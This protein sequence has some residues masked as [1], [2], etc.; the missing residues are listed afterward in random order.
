MQAIHQ[1][2]ATNNENHHKI[3]M[4]WKFEN[5]TSLRSVRESL[6]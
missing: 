1:H 3:H 2:S 6:F 5:I 4:L